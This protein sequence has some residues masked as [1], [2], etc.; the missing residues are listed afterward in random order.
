MDEKLK[1]AITH[2]DINGISY[3]ILLKLL[4]SPE[5]IKL[6]TPI[7]Y[8]SAKVS[9]YYRKVLNFEST[10]WNRIET[11]AEASDSLPNLINCVSDDVVVEMGKCTLEAGIAAYD[12]LER[13]MDDLLQGRVD[14]I[15]TAPINKASMPKDCFPFKGHTA[16]L[17]ARC[18]SDGSSPLMILMANTVK[19]ALATEHI[20]LSAVPSSLTQELIS[21]KL[22]AIKHS[23]IRDFAIDSPRIAVLALNPHAGDNELIGN[24]ETNVISPALKY[25]REQLDINCFGPFSSDGFWGS[26]A[27]MRFDAILAMYHDQ[28]LTPFKALFM[29]KG[30]NFTAGLPIVRTSPDHGTGYDIVGKGIANEASL[31][32]AIY[33]AI[34]ITR[35]RR[36][37]D[38]AMQNPLRKLYV[39]SNNDNEVL[40][41]TPELDD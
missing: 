21:N 26:S 28:G 37:Y 33:A 34:D 30:V 10:P 2:G 5:I 14:A 1:I 24:E 36:R 16:Y 39:S 11:P 17:G 20:P 6:F 31:R 23:L 3:E 22:Q 32:E 8:G 25:C 29:E 7:V 41:P 18:G 19:V 9:A 15:V 40:A 13:A 38:Y 35:N 27:L 4:D 12:A